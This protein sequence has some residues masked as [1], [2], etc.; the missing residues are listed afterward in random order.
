MRK[1]FTVGQMIN[2]LKDFDENQRLLIQIHLG[3]DGVAESKPFYD[4]RVTENGNMVVIE[5]EVI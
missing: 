4:F 2:A 5:S 3:E 1:I